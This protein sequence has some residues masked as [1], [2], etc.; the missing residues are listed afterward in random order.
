MKEKQSLFYLVDLA[1]DLRVSCCYFHQKKKKMIFQIEE[2]KSR[3]F[4]HLVGLPRASTAERFEVLVDSLSFCGA[5]PDLS[6]ASGP[7]TRERVSH[8]R[9]G[10]ALAR[11]KKLS[12]S[13]LDS[14]LSSLDLSRPLELGLPL[15]PAL[16]RSLPLPILFLY[17]PSLFLP[18]SKN[19]KYVSGC[20]SFAASCLFSFRVFL[21]EKEKNTK[22]RKTIF[23]LLP[24]PAA[25]KGASKQA[26][27]ALPLSLL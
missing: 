15:S 22:I 1:K 20:R 8:S 5:L 6:R 26:G 19:I 18:F 4:F 24:L 9:A 27:H 17:L 14:R 13:T 10:L 3:V 25:A 23:F 12:L 21:Q 11:D 2:E 16:A 7:L